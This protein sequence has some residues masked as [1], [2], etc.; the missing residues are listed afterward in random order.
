MRGRSAVSREARLAAPE[1]GLAAEIQYRAHHPGRIL[2]HVALPDRKRPP[3]PEMPHRLDQA[4]GRSLP[5]LGGILEGRG[6]HARLPG[7]Q[8]G[9][10]RRRGAPERADEPCVGEHARQT[11]RQ[12]G[13]VRRAV[14][15]A[16]LRRVRR[17]DHLEPSV[18]VR[19]HVL[20]AGKQDLQRPASA[21][22]VVHV[23]DHLPL[24]AQDIV[25]IEAVRLHR[26]AGSPTRCLERPQRS[27]VEAR[28]PAGLVHRVDV[29]MLPDRPGETAGVGPVRADDE[30]RSVRRR[31]PGHRLPG[32]QMDHRVVGK[33]RDDEGELA[34][35]VVHATRGRGRGV[36]ALDPD[37]ERAGRIVDRVAQLEILPRPAELDALRD[38]PVQKN[39][40]IEREIIIKVRISRRQAE[41]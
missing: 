36:I 29:R 1:K 13:I 12:A 5:R 7:D 21:D 40:D 15:P 8:P 9:R 2:G 3:R 14:D 37:R 22:L 16:A 19:R 27:D 10:Y 20:R 41:A 23:A 31:P 33:I 4:L 30:D 38:L 34:L 6:I 35:I 25:E 39:A 24:S 28:Q 17:P 32:A 26:R 11:D 18:E